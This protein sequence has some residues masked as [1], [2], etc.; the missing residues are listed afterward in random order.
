MNA[1]YKGI[2]KA[3][4]EKSVPKSKNYVLPSLKNRNKDIPK[5]KDRDL[6]K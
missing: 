1:M 6:E 5:S 3:Q 4:E 2:E